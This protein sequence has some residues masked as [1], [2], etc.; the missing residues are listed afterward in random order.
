VRLNQLD[1]RRLVWAAYF[2]LTVLPLMLA[3]F[4][5]ISLTKIGKWLL[6][7][8][9]GIEHG[10]K[11]LHKWANPDLYGRAPRRCRRLLYSRRTVEKLCEKID[12]QRRE[13]ERK[14]E[15]VKDLLGRERQRPHP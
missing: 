15:T 10:G 4:L 3:Y 12:F 1:L 7:A 5:S 6:A 2:G 14:D 11:A 13:I 9:D 8:C